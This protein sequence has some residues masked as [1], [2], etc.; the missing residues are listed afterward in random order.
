[1]EEATNMNA[2]VETS[3]APAPTSPTA[4]TAAKNKQ[5]MYIGVGVVIVLVLAVVAIAAVVLMQGRRTSQLNAAEPTKS[6]A[7]LNSQIKEAVLAAE[8]GQ[9]EQAAGSLAEITAVNKAQFV[10]TLNFEMKGQKMDLTLDGEFEQKSANNIV[11]QGDVTLG[12]EIPGTPGSSFTGINFKDMTMN[13]AFVD[14]KFYFRFVKLPNDPSVLLVLS[15]FG[16][17]AEEWYFVNAS[18]ST[19]ASAATLDKDFIETVKKN[20]LFASATKIA[21]RTVEGVSLDCMDVKLNAAAFTEAE[22]KTTYEM[23]KQLEICT[24]PSADFPMY[25]GVKANDAKTGSDMTMSLVIKSTNATVNVEVPSGAK[26]LEQLL[27][28]SSMFGG[29]A[30]GST[31]PTGSTDNDTPDSLDISIDGEAGFGDDTLDDLYDY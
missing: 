28:N 8:A 14:N 4:S 21:N 5:M 26:D 19:T 6:I 1:M 22:L 18:T 10:L 27:K 23:V 9:T 25:V 17:K 30:A 16:L 24:N 31:Y 11:F 3:A 2:P 20:D 15:L 12:A 7:Y 13:L 29:D